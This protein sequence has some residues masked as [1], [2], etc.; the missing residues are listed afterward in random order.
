MK[1]ILIV[2]LFDKEFKRHLPYLPPILVTRTCPVPSEL[3]FGLEHLCG[4]TNLLNKSSH[5]S[6][7]AP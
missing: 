2:F 4:L 3:F 5:Q 1:N 7:D 6:S